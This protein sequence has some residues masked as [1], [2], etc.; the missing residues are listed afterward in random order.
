MHGFGIA[1]RVEQISRGV[2][3][4]NPGSLLTALQRLERAGWLDAE[5]RQTENSRR[6][7]YL[8]AHPR[9]PEAAR[10]R[11][12]GL[13]PPRRAPSPACS[14]PRGRPVSL[15]RQLTRGVRVADPSGRRRPGRR[16][17]GAALPRS[18]HRRPRRAA[19]SRPTTARRAARVEIGNVTGVQRTGARLRLGKPGRDAPVRP[20]LRRAPPALRTRASPPSPSSRWRSASAPPRR[21]S[22]PSTR[23]SSSRLPYPH[24]GRITAILEVG[25]DG[26]HNSGTFALYRTFAERA[27]SFGTIAALRPWQPT[28]IGGDLPERLEGQRV[29]AGYFQVLGVV[30]V[31]GRDF[32]SSDDRLRGQNVVILE[33]CPVAATLRRRSHDRGAPDRTQ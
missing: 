26:G 28:M 29:S 16:R 5:W 3:K 18:G 1:R 31:A 15:W 4:V 12:R 6:A 2:F 32:D 21:S 27:R 30:P 11:D 13:D 8:R 33:R 20:A 14:R 23:S 19:D 25:R 24:A 10:H 17:R 7:K 22:A 9:R